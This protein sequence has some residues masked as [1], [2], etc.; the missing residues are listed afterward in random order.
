MVAC[1]LLLLLAILFSGTQFI[2]RSPAFHP[3]S[4]SQ[5]ARPR[6]AG[7]LRLGQYTF[8]D[9]DNQLVFAKVKWLR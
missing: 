4:I 5:A 1:V 6:P 9:L 7:G 2:Y 3:P 8:Q